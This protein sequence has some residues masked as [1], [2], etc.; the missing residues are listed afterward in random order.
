MDQYMLEARWV[1][2]GVMV[3]HVVDVSVAEVDFFS[4]AHECLS[5]VVLK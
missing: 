3:A 5:L 4:F 2:R 1:N